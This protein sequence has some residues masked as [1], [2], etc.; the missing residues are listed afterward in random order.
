MGFDAKLIARMLQAI[1]DCANSYTKTFHNLSNAAIICCKNVDGAHAE[2]VKKEY[3]K[4]SE[5]HGEM[6][7]L[8]LKADSRLR[9]LLDFVNSQLKKAGMATVPVPESPAKVLNLGNSNDIA[10]NPTAFKVA[11][12]A[13]L[14]QNMKKLIADLETFKTAYSRATTALYQE[15]NATKA[16]FD[17]VPEIGKM[18]ENTT[19]IDNTVTKMAQ[20]IIDE[21]NSAIEASKP[22][23]L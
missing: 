6:C 18:L 3:K 13:I 1:I 22:W 8:L 17:A 11:A 4:V 12:P 5:K 14:I 9:D 15:Y 20:H 2:L 21:A 7:A 23:H 19:E 10:I 16:G